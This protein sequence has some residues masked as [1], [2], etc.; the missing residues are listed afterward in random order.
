MG[1]ITLSGATVDETGVTADRTSYAFPTQDLRTSLA[2]IISRAVAM[3]VPMA[4][5]SGDLTTRIHTMFTFLKTT[6][7]NMSFAAAMTEMMSVVAD[8]VS[9]FDYSGTTPKLN[10]WRRGTMTGISYAAGG[11]STSLRVESAEI[12]PRTDQHVKRLELKYVTRQAITGLPMWAAQADG[13]AVGS[14]SADDKRKVQIITVSGPETLEVVPADDFDKVV[15]QTKAAALGTAEYFELDETLRSAAE[16]WGAFLGTAG[17]Y[18]IAG[19][20][21]VISGETVDWMR[22]DYGLVKTKTRVKGWIAGSYVSAGGLGLCANYLKSIG[23]LNWN[24]GGSGTTNTFNLFVDFEVETINL[25]YTQATTVR[26]KWD[27]DFL[28]PPAGLAASLRGAQDWIPWEGPVK[29][30]Q[31][32]HD[33]YN[34]VQRKFNLTNSHPD[35]AAMDALVKSITY[36]SD[37][38]VTWDLG[39]PARADLGGLVN[40]LR[41]NPQD[42]IVWL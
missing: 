11:S 28:N 17:A 37:H 27:Y 18:I 24:V 25:S 8:G 29:I 40:K 2:A 33:G 10:L 22:T 38:R 39:P 32:A 12:F 14:L 16:S 35:H 42:N 30:A 31:T 26:K 23:R 3:G 13:T 5:I 4:D 19:Q 21:L 34:G 9:W 6:L 41:R 36:S 7:S 15:I 1:K 20:H